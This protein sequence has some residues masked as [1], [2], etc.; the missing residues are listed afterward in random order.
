MGAFITLEGLSD[1]GDSVSIVL[2]VAIQSF[3]ETMENV[4]LAAALGDS[5]N[6]REA[7][8]ADGLGTIVGALFGAT[9]PTT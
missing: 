8:L 2:P 3:I 1:V 5:Y 6:L 9:L 4:D 7:M